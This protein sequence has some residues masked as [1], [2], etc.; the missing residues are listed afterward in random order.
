MKIST[1]FISEGIAQDASGAYSA[2]RVGQNLVFTMSVPTASKRAIFLNL[3]EEDDELVE[4]TQIIVSFEIKAPSGE[5][6]AGNVIGIPIVAKPIAS[7]PAEIPV[8]AEFVLP[9]ADF[10]EY[11]VSASVA[12]PDGAQL[13][14]SLPLHVLKPPTGPPNG[15]AP[16]NTGSD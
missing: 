10:G 15:P 7:L 3:V 1:F 2:I 6:I 9:L 14:S 13:H 11:T 16:E 5:V 12:L 4:G 8:P